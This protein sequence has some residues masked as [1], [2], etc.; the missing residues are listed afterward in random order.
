MIAIVQRNL[1]PGTVFRNGVVALVPA[2]LI[3]LVKAKVCRVENVLK[4]S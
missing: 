1:I 3:C 4:T 2:V